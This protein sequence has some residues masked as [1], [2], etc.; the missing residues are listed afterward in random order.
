MNNEVLDTLSGYIPTYTKQTEHV[1]CT[2]RK[3]A[4]SIY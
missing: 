1:L 4:Q 2:Y 3:D